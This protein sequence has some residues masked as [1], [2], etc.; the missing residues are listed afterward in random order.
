MELATNANTFTN[1]SEFTEEDYLKL[2]LDDYEINLINTLPDR[3][4]EKLNNSKPSLLELK[5]VNK[6]NQTNSNQKILYTIINN[7]TGLSYDNINNNMNNFKYSSLPRVL[8]V[9]NKNKNKKI[10]DV[11][12]EQSIIYS[13]YMKYNF[14]FEPCR[15]YKKFYTPRCCVGFKRFKRGEIYESNIL[16][17]IIYHQIVPEFQF[18]H[19]DDFHIKHWSYGT[20]C[21]DNI[22][23][24]KSRH[25]KREYGDDSIKLLEFISILNKLHYKI[26][27]QY[28]LSLIDK[29]LKTC[30]ENKDKREGNS[31]YVYKI[32]IYDGNLVFPSNNIL[33]Y[34]INNN[35]VFQLNDIY[36]IVDFNYASLIK[37]IYINKK[38]ITKIYN[39]KRLMDSLDMFKNLTFENNY[40]NE[41]FSIL[42]YEIRLIILSF[43]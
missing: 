8:K 2:W 32:P 26:N 34:L 16:G 41:Y 23:S 43:M 15:N 7:A 5:L 42:P 36:T 20:W 3:E 17:D 10:N 37:Q 27:E 25:N 31:L 12:L 21:I 11:N 6:I 39:N 33:N 28:V 38:I 9:C 4:T 18:H 19:I 24:C 29:F 35:V 14:L 13:K 30:A 22:I 1:D 40:I